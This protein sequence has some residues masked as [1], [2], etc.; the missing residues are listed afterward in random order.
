M[1]AGVKLKVNGIEMGV[2]AV[3]LMCKDNY[4][5]EEETPPP[6]TPSHGLCYME[7]QL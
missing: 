5:T 3:S 6:P 1:R 7:L 2:F 4:A